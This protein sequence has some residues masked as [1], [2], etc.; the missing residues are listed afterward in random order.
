MT[1]TITKEVVF[2]RMIGFGI[3]AAISV[4]VVVIGNKQP[5]FPD[6]AG[7]TFTATAFLAVCYF[8]GIFVAWGKINTQNILKAENFNVD[9]KLEG[10]ILVDKRQRKF[11]L[12]GGASGPWKF[13]SWD[14]IK[15]W[16][17]EWETKNNV[18]KYFVRFD[19][20]DFNCPTIRRELGWGT[21][22][23][24]Q[25]MAHKTIAQI[26]MLIKGEA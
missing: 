21:G 17:L 7:Y 24:P 3:C 19:M 23:G 8:I 22:F 13:L 1:K 9:L 15:A 10:E 20:D 4:I 11:A 26:G 14:N 2:R 12:V 18:T 6:W 5:K 16:Q 25:E